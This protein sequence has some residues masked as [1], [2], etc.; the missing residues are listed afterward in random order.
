MAE[1]ARPIIILIAGVDRLGATFVSA[2]AVRA[3]GK[4]RGDEERES[5]QSRAC[6]RDPLKRW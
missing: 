5:D 2:Q 1:L 6:E 4:A 3:G